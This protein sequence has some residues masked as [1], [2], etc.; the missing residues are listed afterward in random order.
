MTPI[1]PTWPAPQSMV[2]ELV[3]VTGPKSPPDRQ[4]ISP[5]LEVCPIA[6]AKVRQGAAWVQALLSLPEDD[7]QLLVLAA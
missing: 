7:T 1:A 2:I 4:S 5:P 6:C 3:M